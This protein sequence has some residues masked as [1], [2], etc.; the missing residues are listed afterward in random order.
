MNFNA[1]FNSKAIIVKTFSLK[2]F[3]LFVAAA[4]VWIAQF[5]VSQQ[6]KALNTKLHPLRIV[7]NSLVVEDPTQFAIVRNPG[8]SVIYNLQWQVYLPPIRQNETYLL[9]IAQDVESNPELPTTDQTHVLTFPIPSGTHEI[10][11]LPLDRKRT[12]LNELRLNGEKLDEFQYKTRNI[13]DWEVFFDSSSVQQVVDEPLIICPT[14]WTND[15]ESY[16]WIQK[17]KDN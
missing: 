9:C 1:T 13:A 8:G 3:L 7:S 5:V 11:F 15:F 17:T 10:S 2:T 12:T 4:A 14:K 16:L 6:I